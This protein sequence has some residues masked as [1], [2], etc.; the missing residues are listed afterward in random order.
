MKYIQYHSVWDTEE[1]Y[2][3]QQDPQEMNNLINDPAQLQTKI[4]LRHRLYTALA[5]RSGRHAV[6]YTERVS[7]GAVYRDENG[8][9]AAPFPPEWLKSPG[10]VDRMNG[11]FPDSP[12]KLEA[13]KA[14]RPYFPAT[15]PSN[16]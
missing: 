14:G 10:A 7:S 16:K 13:E 3:L 9:G 8:A 4:D 5:D 11:L 15:A 1:L 2:D 6:P 12:A